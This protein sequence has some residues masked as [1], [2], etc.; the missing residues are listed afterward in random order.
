MAEVEKS[1]EESFTGQ[2]LQENT[3]HVY[4]NFKTASKGTSIS[5]VE[6]KDNWIK[7]DFNNFGKFL[8]TSPAYCRIGEEVIEG[9]TWGDVLSAVA[10]RE[11]E[12][13]N[14]VIESLRKEPLLPRSG[15]FLKQSSMHT[16]RRL[17]NGYWID[18]SYDIPSIVKEL[19]LLCLYC[20]YKED[21][22]QIYGVKEENFS[23]AAQTSSDNAEADPKKGP[24]ADVK[25]Q[26]N[27]I[28]L[29]FRNFKS[30]RAATPAYCLIGDG[31]VEGQTWEDILV[32]IANREI[33]ENNPA[34][35]KL[36]NSKSY[37]AS[38]PFFKRNKIR[39]ARLLSNG[40]WIYTKYSVTGLVKLISS[41]C[42]YC[43]YQ[44]D[45]ILIY[46]VKKGESTSAAVLKNSAADKAISAKKEENAS[47]A[48]LPSH[49]NDAA[50]KENSVPHVKVQEDW[51]KLGFSNFKSFIATNPAY[52][53]IGDEVIEGKTWVDILVGITNIEIEKN[54]PALKVLYSEPLLQKN[55][56]PF[57]MK[58]E[59][60]GVS[61]RQLS[62]GYWI[63]VSHNIPYIME[64]ISVLCL[65]C[66]Y[67]KE[68]I[69]V[70]GVKG[71]EEIFSAARPSSVSVN[72]AVK[73]S[74]MPDVK[75]QEDWIKYAFNN[76][77]SFEGTIPVHC[78][79]GDEVIKGETWK[80]ILAAIANREIEKN[81]PA[82][83][84]LCNSKAYLKTTSLPIFS[85]DKIRNGRRLTNGYWVYTNYA[86]PRLIKLIGSFCLYCGYQKDQILIFGV[87]KEERLSA[88]VLKNPAADKGVFAPKKGNASITVRPSP[89]NTDTSKAN[90][91]LDVKVQGNWI[92]LGPDNFESFE[93]TIPAY[94][95]IEGELIEGKT[96]EDILVAVANK[97][98][99]RNRP[100][101]EALYHEVHMGEQGLPFLM[102]IS[103]R[104]AYW[105]PLAGKYW[106]FLKY[107]TPQL[108]KLISSLCLYCGHKQE[109]I[110][111]YGVNKDGDLSAAVSQVTAEEDGV[112]AE[113]EKPVSVVVPENAS[114]K[115]IS[116]NKEGNSI[117]VEQSSNDNA[118]T[119]LKKKPVPGVE[120][121]DNWIELRSE[122]F[123][124]FEGTSPAYCRIASEVIEGKTW[125]D[126]LVEIANREIEKGNPALDALY[127][128]SLG[129]N[130]NLPF[131]M[132]SEIYWIKCR[133]LV[134][135]H[136]INVDFN[137][138]SLVRTVFNLCS[139]CGYGEGQIRI[140]G[141]KNG[142]KA[143]I[144]EPKP[145]PADKDISV[146]KE[147]SKS[148]AVPHAAGDND[149][150]VKE[151][152]NISAAEHQNAESDKEPAVKKEGNSSVAVQA[153]NTGSD[154][155]LKE[156]PASAVKVQ[157]N[158]IK[159]DLDNENF[160]S[161]G[162]TCPAY[163]SI[164]DEVIEGENWEDILVGITN[165]EIEKNNPA[166]G[167]LYHEPLLPNSQLGPYLMKNMFGKSKNNRRLSNGYWVYIN[168]S[169][170]TFMRLIVLLCLHC[171]YNKKQIL[172]Y[173][174][175]KEGSLTAA[176]QPS[177][178]KDNIATSTL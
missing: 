111:I 105:K 88:A 152:E 17:T 46:G 173:G 1:K 155:A 97:E 113:K 126:V 48:V 150:I 99:E 59:I 98:I 157:D 135:K 102:K 80:D 82:V 158:W 170:P 37:R 70:Y 68:Q 141:V 119:T 149:S 90:P 117:I 85:R 136:W 19:S 73:K 29:D 134:N 168:Y 9:E 133:Q 110:Q 22:I 163:C 30:F 50:P 65:F 51:I 129:Q 38:L 139:R 89:D 26:P 130:K 114:D 64:Q 12:K 71:E 124:S 151:G 162:V 66:G 109:Q 77:R 54:N 175:K 96:W 33:E 11:I 40:Y 62:N 176:G 171:R 28:K 156:N 58:N 57:L 112:F 60:N 108:V 32:G 154:A 165:R 86:V 122:N 166:M 21:Q 147:E 47:V 34:I 5:D 18:L 174:V 49:G 7:L 169:T 118:N 16:G 55:D 23:A 35:I 91:M 115:V 143:S 106:I 92:Q 161:F 107:S 164:G 172:V 137:T 15:P 84:R 67:S 53:C 10:E 132:K 42:S 178:D 128:E 3:P 87:K 52:C 94:C 79:A 121:Q 103:M 160:K 146:K 123:K 24:A 81:N 2:K 45:Q 74:P 72:T 127:H 144:A 100:A 61:C 76:S 8:G 104:G 25:V 20:G 13:N 131:L 142:D 125:E 116:I 75:I 140:Y 39:N 177:N 120:V 63:D 43:G 44:K 83:K 14:P 95:C 145:A 4:D 78:S 36:C 93:G 41:L 27:W 69:Q 159:L 101:I 148:A 138:I 6:V 167:D 56:L 31:V 153:S